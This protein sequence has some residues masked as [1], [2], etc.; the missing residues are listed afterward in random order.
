MASGFIGNEV[1]GNRLRVRVP[2]PPLKKS[3]LTA[4][5]MKRNRIYVRPMIGFKLQYGVWS[6]DSEWPDVN[7]RNDRHG[8]RQ[9]ET[10]ESAQDAGHN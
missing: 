10:R 6:G 7:I 9:F 5:G 2:C 4:V 8:F 1:P 3:E